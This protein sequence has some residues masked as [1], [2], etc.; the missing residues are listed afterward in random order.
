MSRVAAIDIG[1]NSTRMLICDLGPAGPVDVARTE[2]VTGLGRGS[3]DT[4][5]LATD[6]IGRTVGVLSEYRQAIDAAQVVQV[7]AVA[8]AATREASNREVFLD[9]A[10]R[11]LGFRPEAIG[12]EEEAS[13]C[14]RG[15]T[16][17]SA[18][19]RDA[20]VID[21][22][23]GSTEFVNHEGGVSV[24]LGSVRLT[25]RQL[26]THPA[27]VNDVAAARRAAGKAM[28]VATPYRRP[29]GIGTAG[30]W[31]SLAA[32]RRGRCDMTAL[33]GTSVRLADLVTLVDRLADMSLEEK[34]AI[35]G[36][37]QLRAPIIL[38]GAIVAEASLRSLNL[39]EVQV[40]VHDILDGVCLGMGDA[41]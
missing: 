28:A 32:M 23:G 8:T 17:R 14:F 11:V 21:I 27:A 19:P 41:P 33:E 37:D 15:A 5:Q 9:T 20:V 1:T 29:V 38:G 16:S 6:S 4:G 34:R 31:T 24:P 18:N 10:E 3:T 30:T 13:L 40:T 22:G 2:R 26:P 35:P 12:G 25:E 36:L 7:R 39:P